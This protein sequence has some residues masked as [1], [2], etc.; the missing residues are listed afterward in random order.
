MKLEKISAIAEILSSIA[1]VLTLVYLA[2]QT[3]QNTSALQANV[4]QGML[5]EETQLIL[6]Q[7]D[8]PFLNAMT[9]DDRE[10]DLDQRLQARTWITA[11]LRVRENHWLQYQAGV[12]DE[13]TWQAYRLPIR[14]VLSSNVGREEWALR[15]SRGEFTEGFVDDVDN[16]LASE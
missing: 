2:V 14:I 9:I 12:I 3:Q 13:T 11:F 1:I 7:L 6:S 5:A 8:Y 16:F 10:L 15:R 4:R